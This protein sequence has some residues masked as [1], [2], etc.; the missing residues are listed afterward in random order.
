MTV[1]FVGQR[2]RLARPNYAE[3]MGLTGRIHF[4][5]AVADACPIPGTD[6]VAIGTGDCVVDW[7]VAPSNSGPRTHC[8]LNQ[9]EPIL[10]SGHAPA[11]LTVEEL[12]PFLKERVAA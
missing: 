7:D 6:L 1:F 11:E 9:L 5:G 8:D 10:P 3:N 4:I 12:L 2:V